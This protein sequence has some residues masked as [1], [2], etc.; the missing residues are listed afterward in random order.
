[1]DGLDDRGRGGGGIAG[2]EDDDGGGGRW[3]GGAPR[4]AHRDRPG[5]GPCDVFGGSAEVMLE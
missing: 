2:E 5:D 3:G 4:G 1:M